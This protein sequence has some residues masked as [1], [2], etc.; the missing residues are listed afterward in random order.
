VED[1]DFDQV[2]N[3]I[4]WQIDQGTPL[5]DRVMIANIVRNLATLRRILETSPQI[6]SGQWIEIKDL[7][8]SGRIGV[9]EMERAAPQRMLISLRFQIESSFA[10]LNDQLE[11]T[12]DYAEVAAE[13]EKVVQATEAHLIEKLVSEIGDALMVRFQMERLEIELRKFI[14]PKARYVS[15]K[16]DWNRAGESANRKAYQRCR[17]SSSN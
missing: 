12:I 9:P 15:V 7:E 6:C 14:L 13:V 5:S 17:A 8:V 16:T 11:K 10:A 2:E 3:A 1:A 4:W